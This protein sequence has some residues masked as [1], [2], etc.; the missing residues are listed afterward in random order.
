MP[1][2][3]NIGAYVDEATMVDTGLRLAHVR[4]LVKCPFIWW[5]W[6]WWRVRTIT[7]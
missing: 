6:H 2:Y 7:G 1:S 5:C 4:K 3:V